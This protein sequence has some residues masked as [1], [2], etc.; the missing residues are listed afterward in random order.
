MCSW[1][2]NR[3]SYSPSQTVLVPREVVHPFLQLIFYLYLSLSEVRQ[4]HYQSFFPCNFFFL[5]HSY[6]L[7]KNIKK[8]VLCWHTIFFNFSRIKIRFC[9]C[10]FISTYFCDFCSMH[11]NRAWWKI[12]SNI[13]NSKYSITF[14]HLL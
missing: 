14:F 10:N 8:L 11:C 13:F 7:S 5:I 4:L 12:C 2:K 1:S 9:F 6:H 3:F